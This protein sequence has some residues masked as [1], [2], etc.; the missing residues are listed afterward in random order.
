MD[1][2]SLGYL[3]DGRWNMMMGCF[4]QI[5]YDVIFV[6]WLS[7]GIQN[8]LIYCLC[9]RLPFPKACSLGMIPFTHK[10]CCQTENEGI[11]HHT[12][13]IIVGMSFSVGI[14]WG[15]YRQSYGQML[16]GFFILFYHSY[17][18]RGLYFLAGGLE[19][20]VLLLLKIGYDGKPQ[21]P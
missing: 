4:F 3:W 18:T 19:P 12:D 1:H 8:I 10:P 5:S 14:A 9:S 17:P 7:D 13:N 20:Q 15:L 6:L 2:S 21:S 16:M 11:N